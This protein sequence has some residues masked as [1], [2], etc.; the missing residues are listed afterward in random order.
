MPFDKWGIPFFYVT[1]R[2]AG[3]TNSGSGFYWTQNNDIH[4]DDDYEGTAMVRIGKEH[5]SADFDVIDTTTGE[6]Q[7][8]FNF[9]SGDGLSLSGPTGH[10]S[11]GE[12]H[13]C[14]G[15][16]YMINVTLEDTPPKFRFRKETFHVNYDDDPQTGVWTHPSAPDKIVG[17]GWFGYGWVRYDRKGGRTDGGDSVVIETWWNND[18]VADIKNWVMLKRREDKGGVS[19]DNWGDGG[20]S[21]GGATESIAGTWSNIQFRFKVDASDFSLHPIKPEF[22]D[23]PNIHSIGEADMDFGKTEDRGYGYSANMPRDIEMKCLFK[24]DDTSGKTRFKNISL[25]EI[26]PT[27]SFGDIP[28][29]PDPTEEPTNTTRTIQGKLKLQWDLNT[30][31]VLIGVCWNRRRRRRRRIIQILQCIYGFGS[32]CR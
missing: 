29:D 25:R 2:T 19:G 14:E 9:N 7:F 15:F 21:C 13:G 4:K 17:G 10:H 1:K 32:R 22:D 6:F 16:T 12:T 11:G 20:I 23:G 3:I 31:R 18:P 30:S 27:L 8:P 26:D 24:M 28:E 5:D